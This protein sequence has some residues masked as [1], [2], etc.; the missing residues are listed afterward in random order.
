MTVV[1]LGM[2]E[3]G[4]RLAAWLATVE[5]FSFYVVADDTYEFGSVWV[6]AGDNQLPVFSFAL[7]PNPDHPNFPYGFEVEPD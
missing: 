1:E 5:E 6:T 7:G 4:W 3:S 2:S